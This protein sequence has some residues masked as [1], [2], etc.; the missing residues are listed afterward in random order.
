[1]A[2]MKGIML[3]GTSSDVG[4]S[5]VATLFC[6]ILA[7]E[8]VKITPF[9]SQNMSNNSYVT[10]DGLEIGRAQGIQAEAANT[11]PS[12]MM[13]PILLKPQNDR[14]SE[15][16]LFGKR[17]HPMDGMDYRNEFYDTGKEAIQ[18]ALHH[19]DKHFEAVVIEGAGSPV[20]MN[21]QSR[22]LVNMAVAKMADVPVILISDIDR[23]GVFASIVGTLALLAEDERARV[24]GII[25]NK[26]RGDRRLFDDGVKWLEDYTK[27][28]VLGVLPY[29]E[30]HGI[31]QEDSLGVAAVSSGN[32]STQPAALIVSVIE[33]PYISNFT[34]IEC[35]VQ[36]RGAAV[37]WVK[38]PA[39]LR[40][41]P[42]LLLIPGTKSTIHSLRELKRLGWHE[43]LL[44]LQRSGVWIMGICGGFQMLGDRLTDP[45][46]TD[47]G[48]AG[49]T[50]TGFGMISS[51]TVFR[52]EKQV[53]KRSGFI[54]SPAGEPLYPVKGYEIHL[55]K[56]IVQ[57]DSTFSPFLK[58]ENG[59]LD[60]CFSNDK[61]IIGTYLHDIFREPASRTH[62]LNEI[63]KS[64]G[65]M[66]AEGETKTAA[67]NVYD[68]LA[69]KL[70]PH[71]KWNEIR[72]I[73]GL[74]T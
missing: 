18:K 33:L 62:I 36:E 13:N 19:L 8:N 44:Q 14:S 23:G 29:V 39:D 74:E 26:F 61:R 10:K 41:L 22:E 1:M 55:G 65:L 43:K 53:K 58:L 27:I 50:E 37:S 5:L 7:Q 68:K 66:E 54:L 40:S 12:A 32:S 11:E 16:I 24:K 49:S 67:G 20:E 4:K 6:R 35:L 70:K 63:R 45:N 3:Q 34:D 42:D 30:Q 64:K 56:T 9:K 21:L 46:G 69:E 60:G 31:E 51:S 38:R 17:L 2:G 48:A 28:P 57:E 52:Q 72:K 47:T 25:I 15:V 73:M 71:L 59:E